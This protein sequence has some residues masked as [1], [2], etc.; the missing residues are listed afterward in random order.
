MIDSII[1]LKKES[2]NNVTEHVFAV[3][4]QDN[5]PIP[6]ANL[7]RI[8]LEILFFKSFNNDNNNIESNT[9]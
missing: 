2:N 3:P 8:Y 9:F 7:D 1:N 5:L 6:I 4:I